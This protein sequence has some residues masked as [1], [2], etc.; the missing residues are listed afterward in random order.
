MELPS[1]DDWEQAWTGLDEACAYRNFFG[2]SLAE[3]YELFAH[4]A[5]TYQEDLVYMPEKPFR[6]YVRAFIHYMRSEKSK[7]DSDAANCFLGLVETRLADHSEWIAD[8]W[9]QINRTLQRIAD[10]QEDY[11][12]ASPVIYGNF[13]RKVNRLIEK[14]IA[15]QQGGGD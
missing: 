1:K 6:F 7:G 10:H 2:K 9:S 11:Y 14:R 5:L 13:R 4:C 8:S 3:A 12:D 15:I